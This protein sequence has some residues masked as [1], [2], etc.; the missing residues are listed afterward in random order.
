MKGKILEHVTQPEMGP[1]KAGIHLQTPVL[2]CLLAARVSHHSMFVCGAPPEDSRVPP[3]LGTQAVGGLGSSRPS[4]PSPQSSRLGR[5]VIWPRG[6]RV[7]GPMSP[8]DQALPPKAHCKSLL[9]LPGEQGAQLC[10]G[11]GA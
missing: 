2:L 9:A 10:R 4:R 1:P 5:T 3:D 6:R 8:P 11:R 7:P